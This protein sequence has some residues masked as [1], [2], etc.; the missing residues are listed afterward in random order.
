MNEIETRPQLKNAAERRSFAFA[1][2]ELRSNGENRLPTIRG[3]AA[4]FNSLSEDLGRYREVVL[5]GAFSRSLDRRD[6]TICTWNHNP[7]EL[8]GRIRSGTLQ[9]WE[10]EKGLRFVVQPPDTT[11]ARN[12][13]ALMRRGDVRG[14]SFGFVVDGPNGQRWTHRG[15]SRLRQLVTVRLI[16]VS[17]VTTPAY[18]DAESSL[19]HKRTLLDG[20]HASR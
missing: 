14:A 12:V 5:P 15:E 4:V 7:S 9:L 13:I 3:Y 11:A 6:D 2:L 16:D 20:L 1:E 18:P 17:V 10:D 8:L 19:R